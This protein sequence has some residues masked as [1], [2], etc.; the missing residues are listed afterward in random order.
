MNI[1][2]YCIRS[3]KPS[4]GIRTMIRQEIHR[5]VETEGQR[6]P[7]SSKVWLIQ[8]IL[9]GHL[10]TS[11]CN[12]DDHWTVRGVVGNRSVIATAHIYPQRRAVLY[13]NGGRWQRHG[14]LLDVE[15]LGRP[16]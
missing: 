7:G 11:P 8:W 15:Q 9:M 13:K 10:H 1:A 14:I 5:I 4:I 16:L 12:R 2:M 3:Y 6:Y